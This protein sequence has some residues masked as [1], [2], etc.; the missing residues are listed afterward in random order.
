MVASF[1]HARALVPASPDGFH[2]D[3][4]EGW[5]QGR[6]AF[7]GLVL[8]TLLDAMRARE[9]D[10]ARLPRALTGELCGPC[11]P[12]RGL[13]TTHLLRRGNNQTNVT[14]RLTQDGDTVAHA[15]LTMATARKVADVPAMTMPSPPR[16]H[17]EDVPI[18]PIREPIGP[19]FAQHYEYRIV[20]ALPFTSQSEAVVQGYVRERTT[21]QVLTHA[22]IIGRLDAFYPALF[23]VSSAPRPMA[24][25]SFMAELLADPATLDPA[26]PL[27]YRARAVA[28]EG[29][30]FVELREL[31]S[32]DTVVALNQ[33]S[34][35]ILK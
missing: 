10:L 32:G 20:G 16:P 2:W 4:P 12:R 8:A 11:L 14:A 28:H 34:F 1:D 31:W 27:F 19:A 30:Y 22:A 29:G 5:Q 9:P 7:G 26:V 35:A 18:A 23:N 6:G 13:V 25:V 17:W 3:V 33:Q 15:S 24:T 21:L